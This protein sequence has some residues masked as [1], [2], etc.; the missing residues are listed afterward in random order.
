MLRLVVYLLGIVA[1]AA[2]FSWLADRPGQISFA[3]E[4]YEGEITVFRAVVIGAVLLGLFMFMWSLLRTI[5]FGPAELGRYFYRRRQKRGLDALSSGMIAIGAGDKANAMRYAIQA[6][7][8]LPNEPLTHLLRAQ[9][10]QLSGDKATS[11]RIFEAMLATPDTEQLGL[12]GLFL[13]AQ[14][15]GEG[16]AARQFA[17]R[18]IALNPR[19]GWSAEALFELQ[20]KQGDWAG[21]LTSLASAKKFGHVEKTVADRRRAVLLTAQAQAIEDS[22]AEKAMNLALEAHALAPGL[23]PAAAIAARLLASRGNVSKAA[24]VIQKTWLKSP[25]P[26]LAAA[27]AYARIGDSPRDRLERVRQLAALTTNSIEG[28]IAVARTAIEARDFGVARY[29]LEPLLDGRVT[30]RVATLM[31]RIEAEDSADKGR[32]REWLARAGHAQRDPAW[33]ADG[34]VADTWA[35]VS[36]VTGQL[37]A[38]EWKVPVEIASAEGALIAQQMEQFAAIEAPAAARVV[39]PVAGPVT[40]PAAVEVAKTT[41]APAAVSTADVAV[42]PVKA[43]KVEAKPAAAPQTVEAEVVE[44]RAAPIVSAAREAPAAPATAAAPATPVTASPAAASA[45]GKA[46]PVAATAGQSASAVVTE[47]TPAANAVA[48]TTAVSASAQQQPAPAPVGIDAST[49]DLQVPPSAVT[50]SIAKPA[51][52]QKVDAPAASPVAAAAAAAK[53]AT[54]AADLVAKTEPARKASADAKSKSEPSIFISP[55]APDDPGPDQDDAEA[56]AVGGGPHR[57][58]HRATR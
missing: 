33:T 51:P 22:D 21:A 27:Y 40:P 53:P 6:R 3:W 39:E 18:A 19:L 16:E 17:E 2:G 7:K 36:P 35:P 15:E 8:T 20:C 32:V 26:D 34:V 29:A 56:G 1:L 49:V 4:G 12:R 42:A 11:R 41:A 31:A 45:K 30:Q 5:W 24:K 14:R 55:R 10:A 46:A 48:A 43:P 9:A 47:A 58:R 54:R 38:F 37:D 23:V 57:Q 28:P 13:E 52:S 25:H 44:T 50:P